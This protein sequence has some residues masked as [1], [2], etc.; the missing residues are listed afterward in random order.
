MTTLTAIVAR[1]TPNGVQYIA[2]PGIW[3]NDRNQAQRMPLNE[4]RAM[5]FT[6][7]TKRSPARAIEIQ[8]DPVS[9]EADK[10]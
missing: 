7:S 10:S 8:T 1:I 5:A 2:A 6:N 4:A 9:Q 3:Q